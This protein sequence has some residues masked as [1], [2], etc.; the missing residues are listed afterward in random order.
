MLFCWDTPITITTITDRLYG[1]KGFAPF[2][3]CSYLQLGLPSTLLFLGTRLVDIL[4][5]FLRSFYSCE[6]LG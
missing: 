4:F 1:Q 2:G 5:L 6:D 3:K